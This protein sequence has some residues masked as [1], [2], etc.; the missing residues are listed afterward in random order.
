[1]ATGFP[2]KANWS[3]GDVLTGSQMDDLAGTLNYLS[4]VGQAN[5]STLVANSANASG[6]GWNQNFA[7]GKNAIINGDFGVWQ[8]GTTFTNP[9]TFVYTSDRWLVTNNGTSTGSVTRQ[10]FTPGSSPVAGYESSYFLQYAITAASGASFTL[11]EQRIEDVRKFA[12][13]TITIS[14]WAK[15]DATRTLNGRVTQNF[16]SGGSADV[17]TSFSIGSVTSSWVRYSTTVAVPAITGKTIGTSSFLS[18]AFDLPLNTVL[19]F[20]IWGVQAEAGSVA[21][22]FQTATG[23]L[24]GELAAC[25]R[26][27]YTPTGGI[28]TIGSYYSTTSCYTYINLPVSMRTTPTLTVV[29]QT[30]AT[31]FSAG[32][33]RAATAI[34]SD[35]PTVSGVGVVIT[36]SAAT[37][38]NVGSVVI[39]NGALFWSAEL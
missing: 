7:A 26:Y 9:G 29:S 1:M 4:P 5:G 2:T 18:I 22:A 28:G 13:Q 27:G 12:G 8:R 21:T 37:A 24:Q 20:G 3:A 15:F 32:T 39:N 30:G 35:T 34:A 33:S 36:T 16:G 6:L 23:T 14:F 10:T 31:V 38:G 25:Q 19:T 17:T 11:M